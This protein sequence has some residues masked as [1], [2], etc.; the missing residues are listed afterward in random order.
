MINQ[1]VGLI[2]YNV[3]HRKTYDVLCLLKAKGYKRVRVYAQPMRYK[4]T[5]FPLI[6]HRPEL[7]INIPEPSKLCYNLGYIYTEGKINEMNIPQ[8]MPLLICGAGILEED[9]VR[10]HLIINAHPGY[11]PLVR[12]L[13]S[14]KWAIWED[15]PIGVTTHFL[16][17]Y[18]DGGEIIERRE[19]PVLAEDTFFHVALRVYETEV[20][21]L[22]EALDKLYDKHEFVNPEEYELHRRMPHEFEMELLG[23]F[24]KYK[25]NHI[26]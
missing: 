16:G 3:K 25:Q 26:N 9:F 1:E 15:K 23:K 8:N 19:I 14:L 24:E 10:N 18:V 17:K 7:I 11:I 2:T 4:K 6:I 21:M 12:G 5:F 22:V 13:D 20:S